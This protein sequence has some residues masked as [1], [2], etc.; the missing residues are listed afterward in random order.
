MANGFDS[1]N[2]NLV[3]SVCEWTVGHESLALCW[4]GHFHLTICVPHW[5]SSQHIR[6]IR[7]ANDI[8]IVK[9]VKRVETGLTVHYAFVCAAVS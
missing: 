8:I 1:I 3:Q 2:F 6:G 9:S 5:H 7:D 4:L